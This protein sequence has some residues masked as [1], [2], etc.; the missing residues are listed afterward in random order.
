MSSGFASGLRS[1][2]GSTITGRDSIVALSD[3]TDATRATS[4]PGGQQPP[5]ASA[6]PFDTEEEE[7][8][9]TAGATGAAAG[10]ATKAGA[11]AGAA[12][13]TAG[14]VA[15]AAAGAAGAASGYAPPAKETKAASATEAPKKNFHYVFQTVE[16]VPRAAGINEEGTYPFTEPI[17]LVNNLRGVEGKEERKRYALSATGTEPGMEPFKKEDII[18]MNGYAAMNLI[19]DILNQEEL[20]EGIKELV[21]FTPKSFTKNSDIPQIQMLFF[22]FLAQMIFF[23]HLAKP[24]T[25]INIQTT[26]FAEQYELVRKECEAGL[27][28]TPDRTYFGVSET[29]FGFGQK[30]E[31]NEEEHL[32]KSWWGRNSTGAFLCV[33]GEVNI[34]DFIE[35]FVL[36]PAAMLTLFEI[37]KKLMESNFKGKVNLNILKAYADADAAALNSDADLRQ[38]L[39][40]TIAA[41]RTEKGAKKPKFVT[42]RQLIDFLKEEIKK[43]QVDFDGSDD[44]GDDEDGD[45]DDDDEDEAPANPQPPRYRFGKRDSD[46]DPRILMHKRSNTP[47]GGTGTGVGESAS[48]LAGATARGAAEMAVSAGRSALAAAGLAGRGASAIGSGVASAAGLAGRAA[49]RAASAIGSSVASAARSESPGRRS[50][51]GTVPSERPTAHPAVPP[52]SGLPVASPAPGK[53]SPTIALPL[54]GPPGGLIATAGMASAGAASGSSAGG[55]S[56]GGEKRNRT[57]KAKKQE[58]GAEEVQGEPEP[59]TIIPIK[60]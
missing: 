9:A 57:R 1:T 54:S 28:K 30:T 37:E 35:I 44:E 12:G 8:A 42:A 33:A 34:S 60:L 23:S 47:L 19:I 41:I 31:G 26:Q 45:E 55:C 6:P 56:G 43:K 59:Q 29:K 46:E 52:P 21:C 5:V 10:P 11:A 24:P 17:I 51:A 49:G 58:G 53:R 14:A 25:P 38:E 16:K 27:Q 40:N 20:P 2:N 7:H 22:M 32:I 3:A 4:D 18:A 15:G 48:A 39:E 50:P 13:A 36:G